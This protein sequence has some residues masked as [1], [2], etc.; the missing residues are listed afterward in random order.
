MPASRGQFVES[1]PV[2]L[3]FEKG[4]K[5][6]TLFVERRDNPAV[7]AYLLRQG[8]TL[9]HTSLLQWEFLLA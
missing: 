5:L 8:R 9:R 6:E 1:E 7:G 3:P 2:R 4:E